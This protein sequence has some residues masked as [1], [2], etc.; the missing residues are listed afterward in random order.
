MNN[1]ELIIA[2]GN[3][4]KIKE[5]R[6]ALST[7][8][9]LPFAIDTIGAS[10]IIE[11]DEPYLTFIDNAIHKC[12]YYGAHTNKITLSEDAGLCIEGL[13]NWPG[14][15][16]KDFMYQYGSVENAIAKLEEMMHKINNK[17][18]FFHCAAAIY[19]PQKDWLITHEARI[20]GKLSM[21]SLAT[22]GLAFDP[23]F[24]PDGYTVTL[25][26]VSTEEKDKIGHRGK[27]I[28]GL[29]TNLLAMMKHERQQQRQS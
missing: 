28:R 10:N 2:S 18:A 1:Y 16:T 23:I 8:V 9:D 3:S 14:I 13:N 5:I 4:G 24:I 22:G 6:H 11:P 17:N 7:I 29:M 20:H 21:P 12:R 27:A 26:E 25:A 19:W 15:K